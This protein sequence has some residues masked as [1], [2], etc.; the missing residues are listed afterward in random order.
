MLAVAVLTDG[1][2]KDDVISTAPL[3]AKDEER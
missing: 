2:S 1:R 3:G